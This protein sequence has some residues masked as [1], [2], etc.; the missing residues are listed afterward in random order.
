MI[1]RVNVCSSIR[2]YF[3]V[4]ACQLITIYNMKMLAKAK[5]IRCLSYVFECIHV[6]F[7]VQTYAYANMGI[8]T[9]IS[10]LRM[11]VKIFEITRQI[12]IHTFCNRAFVVVSKYRNSSQDANQTQIYIQCLNQFMCRHF[13]RLSYESYDLQVSLPHWC[14]FKPQNGTS[15]VA[16]ILKHTRSIYLKR[17][18]MTMANLMYCCTCSASRLFITHCS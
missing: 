5:W 13:D 16:S 11:G 3:Q 15:C 18:H 17:T 2:G 1:L 9:S 12:N 6:A 4:S 8:H 7:Q 14:A 10:V